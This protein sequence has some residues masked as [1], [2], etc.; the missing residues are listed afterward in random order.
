MASGCCKVCGR[1]VEYLLIGDF[2][3]DG[4]KSKFYEEQEYQRAAQR[5]AE[6][7]KKEQIFRDKVKTAASVASAAMIAE[8][9]AMMKEAR[10]REIAEEYQKRL[11][12]EAE[13][14]EYCKKVGFNNADEARKWKE[15]HPDLDIDQLA[16]KKRE[17][18]KRIE[19][20]NKRSE[21][22]RKQREAAYAQMDKELLEKM[23]PEQQEKQKKIND[24]LLNYKACKSEGWMFLL[25]PLIFAVLGFILYFV[26][27]SKIS[28]VKQYGFWSTVLTFIGFGSFL[29][30][31][32]FWAEFKNTI[33]KIAR[34][35]GDDSYPSYNLSKLTRRNPYNGLVF[36]N[37]VDNARMSLNIGMVVFGWIAVFKFFKYVHVPYVGVIIRIL[38]VLVPLII[39]ITYGA[40]DKKN[41]KDMEINSKKIRKY[42]EKKCGK[43]FLGM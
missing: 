1:Y 42:I 25:L 29:Y 2:C 22:K 13:L 14:E 37:N 12:E 9:T 15:I 4:C 31:L 19:E 33:K 20:D 39:A 35:K 27:R 3:S 18:V 30:S 36:L 16:E 10:R 5:K 8:Q 40:S 21:E 34:I 26:F 23:N 11:Q 24:V 38:V 7:E 32:I 17:A 28:F 6:E 43:V 41:K